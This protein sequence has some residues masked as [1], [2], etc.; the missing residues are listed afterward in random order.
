MPCP[1]T[2]PSPALAATLSAS[3]A[4]PPVAETAPLQDHRPLPLPLTRALVAKDAISS[5]QD[6]Q[7]YGNG[8]RRR[9][10]ASL[11]RS[12]ETGSLEDSNE[13]GG[14]RAATVVVMLGRRR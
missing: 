7:G 2:L 1:S 11:E 13:T 14:C 12:N 8:L 6:E 3:A 5:P 4:S 10:P 9:D